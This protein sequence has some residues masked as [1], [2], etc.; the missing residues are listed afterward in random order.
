MRYLWIAFLATLL[1]ACNYDFIPTPVPEEV[2]EVT[3]QIKTGSGSKEWTIKNNDLSVK[4]VNK[5]PNGA[6]L[7]SQTTKTVPNSYNWLVT[8]LENA[9]F[10]KVT[11]TA[12]QGRPSGSEILIVVT[13]AETY[14]YTQDTRTKFPPGFDKV[15]MG[16]PVVFKA[17]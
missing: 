3:Y 5:S 7:S 8:G 14:T 4:L 15:V 10:T 17:N 16:I 2:S 13:Q 9:D 11:S 6:T 1:S 12:E